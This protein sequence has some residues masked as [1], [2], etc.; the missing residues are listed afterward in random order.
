MPQR[1]DYAMFCYGTFVDNEDMANKIINAYPQFQLDQ[2]FTGDVLM[3]G[4]PN[5]TVVYIKGSD[6]VVGSRTGKFTDTITV[7]NSPQQNITISM[8]NRTFTLTW[9]IV[10]WGP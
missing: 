8:D 2:Q 9:L 6:K 4:N 5:T 3:N 1:D 10:I 7:S